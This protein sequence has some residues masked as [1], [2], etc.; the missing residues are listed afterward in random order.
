MLKKQKGFTLV[1]LL[2]VVAIINILLFIAYP[3]YQDY[4][5]G[6]H[7][8]NVKMQILDIVSDLERI[9]GKNFSYQAIFDSDGNYILSQDI[10]R[11]PQQLNEDKR[12]DIEITNIS[13]NEFTIIATATALQSDNNE[14]LKIE[15]N[16][17]EIKGLKDYN[18][19][20]TWIERWY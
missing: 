5:K 12:F 19:E 14:K 1:E 18:G 16:G 13:S 3:A 10:F 15:Y 6:S 7:E 9:K 4:I 20:D 2:S 8:D 17:Q 11:Y